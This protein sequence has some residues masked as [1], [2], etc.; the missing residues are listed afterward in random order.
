VELLERVQRRAMKGLFSL[1][2][3]KLWE[4]LI[5]AFQYL[6]GVYKQERNLPFT[7]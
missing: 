2:E 5:K 7:G 4:D 3:R 1:Y 6:K